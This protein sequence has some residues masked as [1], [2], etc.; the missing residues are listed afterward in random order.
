M[1]HADR[2]SQAAAKPDLTIAPGT[3]RW[4]GW[5]A[6][7]AAIAIAS[8]PVAAN[9]QDL[10]SFRAPNDLELAYVGLAAD[11]LEPS[12]CRRISPYALH[13]VRKPTLVRSRC[14]YYLAI[15]SGDAEWCED[16]RAIPA[17]VGVMNWLDPERCRYQVTRLADTN[18]RFPVRFDVEGVL[19][20]AG[21]SGEELPRSFARGDQADWQGFYAYLLKE[22]NDPAGRALRRRLA[23]LPDFSSRERAE[24][25]PLYYTAQEQEREY[26]WLTARSHRLCIQGR[27][28]ADCAESFATVRPDMREIARRGGDAVG[29]G[30]TDP[31]RDLARNP[32]R[33]RDASPYRHPTELE[34][35][36]YDMALRRQ[37]Q[38]V[39]QWIPEEVVVV[40]WSVEPGLLFMTLRAACHLAVAA[41]SEDGDH[42]DRV[43]P[44][45]RED[46]EGDGVTPQLCRRMARGQ[47]EPVHPMTLKP[48]WPRVLRALGY[49]A[50]GAG[51]GREAADPEAAAEDLAG[52][53]A[54]ADDLAD[55]AA[56]EHAAFLAR[57]SAAAAVAA[58]DVDLRLSEAD[59]R[60]HLYRLSVIRFHCS[61]NR[62][63]DRYR[64]KG[65]SISPPARFG[66]RFELV[67]HTGRPVTNEDFRGRYLLVYFG[68]TFCPDVCPTSLVAMA[69]ALRQLG[70]DAGAVQPLFISIDPERDT[71]AHLADY[72]TLFHPRLV[73]LTGSAAQIRRA[74][75][76]YHAYYFAG[77]VDGDYVVDHTSWTYLVAPDGRPLTYFDHGT[78]S[79]DIATKVAAML[80]DDNTMLPMTKVAQ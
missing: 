79:N 66:G 63:G 4:R 5:A 52:W 43:R 10:T 39:C 24:D 69:E 37:D 65:Y 46:L 49:A 76:S 68:Y 27:I 29:E 17:G 25:Q 14:F 9:A 18:R 62:Y 26:D 67:D 36:A 44:L 13:R 64:Y 20:R 59:L 8:L 58:S 31:S 48:D 50:D 60:R 7:L 30:A 47:V 21:Y 53:L 1:R 74:A 57:L 41:V 72:V 16:V 11:L 3:G 22:A 35:A 12:F 32:D 40:G 23:A 2:M 78:T 33:D 6:A 71:P 55:P 19:R 34:K 61:I 56:P 45:S 28:S 75:K 42:C 54:L 70:D 38:A 73:G 15:N 51:E 77:E 80:K